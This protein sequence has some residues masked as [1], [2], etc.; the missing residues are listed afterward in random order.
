M[1][2]KKLQ[3]NIDKI[4]K[5][6][7]G[8]WHPLSILARLYEEVGELSRAINI[9]YGDKKKKSQEDG[10]EI[11]TEISDVI[12]TIIAMAN[13]FNINLDK[14]LNDKINKDLERNKGIYH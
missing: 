11:E 3:E 5:I 9:K 1:E 4:I 13:T 14:E 8:Y 2:I 10:R 7:G 12:F 6:Y